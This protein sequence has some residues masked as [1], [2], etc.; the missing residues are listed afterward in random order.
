MR[1][2]IAKKFTIYVSMGCSR[3]PLECGRYYDYFAANGWEYTSS[4]PDADLILVYTC[5]GFQK[6]EDQSLL[7]IERALKEKKHAA[8]LVVTGCLTKINNSVLQ[9]EYVLLKPEELDAMDTLIDARIKLAD[10]P[11]P[12]LV[13]D[14]NGLVPIPRSREFKK[15]TLLPS[16]SLATRFGKQIVR[17]LK[18]NPDQKPLTEKRYYLR[19][20]EGCLGNC[21]YCAIK[22]ACGKLR[23]KKMDSILG[24]F[25][26]GIN[27]GFKTFVLL[28]EDTG[29][30]GLDL[31]TNI[32]AL[33]KKMFD[34]DGHYGFIIKDFNPHWLVRFRQTL[35]PLLEKNKN[36]LTDLRIPIQSGSDRVLRRMRRPYKIEDV[37]E[38][39]R[40]LKSRIPE[41][42]IYTHFMVGFPG[43]TKGDFNQT[44]QFLKEFKLEDYHVY[45]FEGRPGTPAMNF[46]EK[47]S[48]RVKKNRKRIL[49]NL[50]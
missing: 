31:G 49:E 19:I 13:P 48:A 29:C 22:I 33:L 42:P 47:I 4:N 5:G 27:A 50:K 16:A 23:S 44:K 2:N 14:I 20:A 1:E 25:K 10:T 37:K 32:V 30:Y 41:L 6:T 35:I 43:E 9:G 45:C 24:E 26:K 3:R 34:V 18:K 40:D 15:T 11:H 28:A 36:K 39:L 7:T 46:T 38:C 8:K 17:L 12:N 21:T